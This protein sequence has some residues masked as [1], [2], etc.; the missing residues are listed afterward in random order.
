[1][2]PDTAFPP[3][4]SRR[5][6]LTATAAA[7]GAATVPAPPPAATR[8]PRQPRD[9]GPL[10]TLS[11]LLA[12][13]QASERVLVL[14]PNDPSWLDGDAPQRRSARQA[15]LW[16]WSPTGDSSLDHLAPKDTW[17][18]VSEAKYRL[19]N[20][21]QWLLTCASAGLAAVVPYPTGR[22]YWSTATSGNVHTLELLPDGNV[23][24]AASEAGFVRL[25]AASQGP[26]A[27]RCAQFDL[28]GAHGLQWDAVRQVLWALGDRLLVALDV[29]GAPDDPRLTTV[30]AVELP[31]PGGHD[32]SVRADDGD[33]LWVTT[34]GHVYQYSVTGADFTA[35]LGQQDI[36]GPGVKSVGDDPLTGQVLTVAPVTDNPCPW[37][38]STI[39]FHAPD[40]RQR[41]E[42]ASLYK[43]RWMPGP[44][45]A[46]LGGPAEGPW[47]ARAR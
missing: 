16:S 38:T 43:A 44:L 1:M 40:G 10:P 5:D 47:A 8:R 29:G 17:R 15:A 20:G 19:S 12:A 39:D 9:D 3:A 23:A 18:L 31:A 32:L 37:C 33:R 34:V 2:G 13:D 22:A 46:W 45:S 21:R 24:I 41:V 4:P 42:G 25:Y 14:D 26:R 28:P 30:L 27:T 11:L 7:L 6:V 35:Y 36:D